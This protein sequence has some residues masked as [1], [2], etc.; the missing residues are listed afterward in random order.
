MKNKSFK[1]ILYWGVISLLLLYVLY[2]KG[3]IA[4]VPSI[5]PKEAFNTLQNDRNNTYLVVDVRT[6]DE[7]IHEGHLMDAI[8]MPL[9]TVPQQMHTLDKTK[10]LIVYCHSGS[11]SLQAS[12]E[13]EKSGFKVLNVKGGLTRWKDEGL[14]LNP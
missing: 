4:S 11:R 14:S 6:H 10:T 7:Y 5:T 13:L 2:Q 1:N 12:R 9:S 3:F 8:L